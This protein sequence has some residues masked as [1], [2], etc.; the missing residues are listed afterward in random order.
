MTLPLLHDIIMLQRNSKIN[1]KDKKW[2]WNGVGRSKPNQDH[3]FPKWKFSWMDESLQK[4][5]KYLLTGITDEPFFKHFQKS[6]LFFSTY[7]KTFST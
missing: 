5:Y 2:K 7:L 4:H 6:Y 3:Y 1:V